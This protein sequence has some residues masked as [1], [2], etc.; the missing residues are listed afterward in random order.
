M[1]CAYC[2]VVVVFAVSVWRSVWAYITI[3]YVCSATDSWEG[4]DWDG[5]N[6][7]PAMR[8]EYRDEGKLAVAG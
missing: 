8:N 4:C 1:L 2:K 3:V 7:S 5:G 6:K